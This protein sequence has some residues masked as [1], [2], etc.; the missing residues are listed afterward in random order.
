MKRE[1]ARSRQ[2]SQA[3][4]FFPPSRNHRKKAIIAVKPQ[5]SAR[6]KESPELI[7]LHLR[8]ALASASASAAPKII[9]QRRRGASAPSCGFWSSFKGGSPPRGPRVVE[10]RNSQR[11]ERRV[12]RRTRSR[13]TRPWW[14][15]TWGGIISVR[16]KGPIV[17]CS[18]FIMKMT[19]NDVQLFFMVQF[20]H[21]LGL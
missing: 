6:F 18:Q 3:A 19:C 16:W 5:I 15:W 4:Y 8:I 1:I 12:Q 9:H 10:R 21:N 7:F 2:D 11:R 17:E 20:L 13:R 14:T